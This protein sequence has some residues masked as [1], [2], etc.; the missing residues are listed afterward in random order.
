MRI[1]HFVSREHLSSFG[2]IARQRDEHDRIG[3][4]L[5]RAPGFLKGS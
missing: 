2:R 4:E 3:R 1:Y 5:A